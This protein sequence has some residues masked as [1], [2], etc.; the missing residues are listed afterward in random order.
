MRRLVIILTVLAA[1]L[2]L[3]AATLPW[4]LGAAV[5]PAARSRGITVGG[6]ERIGYTRFALRDVDVPVG[7]V[8]V[9][10]D[11]VEADTPLL[12]LWRH[13]RGR[14]GPVI[15]GAWRVEI[16][17]STAPRDPNKPRGWVPLRTL[18]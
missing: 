16:A 15:V 5:R 11:R 17:A 8:R 1:G 14:G 2:V 9:S 7:S 4:W 18:L 10:V 6:Y 13:W 12:W 3:L